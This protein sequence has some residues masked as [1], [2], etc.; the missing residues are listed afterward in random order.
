MKTKFLA[1]F[2]GVLLTSCAQQEKMGT[3]YLLNMSSVKQIQVV[4]TSGKALTVPKG[5]YFEG[6][7]YFSNIMG[8]WT[9]DGKGS[10]GFNHCAV[11]FPLISSIQLNDTGFYQLNDSLSQSFLKITSYTQITDTREEYMYVIDDEWVK[12]AILLSSKK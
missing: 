3:L 2:L 5:G 9:K 8:S 12:Q 4:S 11:E 1:L 10:Y 6:L 7:V